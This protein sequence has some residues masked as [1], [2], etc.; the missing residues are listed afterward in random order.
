MSFPYWHSDYSH[1]RA[2]A[3]RI[4]RILSREEFPFRGVLLGGARQGKTDL[5]RQIQAGLFE[6]AEGPIPFFYSF[7]EQRDDAALAH[8]FVTAFCQQTR[9]F[10]MRQEEMLS[11][12]VGDLAGELDRAG[13]PL[14][15]AELARGF[16]ALSPAHQLEFAANLPAHFAHR[17]SRPVCL[18]LDD[19]HNLNIAA[20]FFAALDSRH[21]SWLLTGRRATMSRIALAKPWP[22]T[23]LEPFSSE[24]MLAFC[25]KA[26]RAAA[27]EFLPEAW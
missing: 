17:E 13:M 26:C 15:L 5:L 16:L 12:P 6:R 3:E 25:K 2:Q 14:S 11:E 10:L 18:L 23:G 19:V 8:H 20:P 22:L 7:P 1:P 27:T 21:L 9:A 4:V 24:E